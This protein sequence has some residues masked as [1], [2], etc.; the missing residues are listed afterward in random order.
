MKK[1]AF[2]LFLFSLFSN[3]YAAFTVPEDF[4]L[5]NSSVITEAQDL[6][7]LPNTLRLV[8]GE[9]ESGELF[10]ESFP[11]GGYC[12]A[13]WQITGEGAKLFPRENT[14]TVLGIFPC[15]ETV[16]LS[17]EDG[18]AFEIAVEVKPKK[19][20]AVR[21]FDY[22]GEPKGESPSPRMMEFSAAVLALCGISLL[23]F[24]ASAFKGAKTNEE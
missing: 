11:A 8:I 7:V 16:T 2:V 22:E 10:A 14:C 6:R 5:D 24:A 12:D 3:A 19:H 23:V 17:S 1:L 20:K 21:S 18:K 9:G 4:Y 13:E 15:R